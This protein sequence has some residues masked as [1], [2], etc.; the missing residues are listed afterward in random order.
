MGQPVRSYVVSVEEVHSGDDLVVMANLG[1]DG[2]HKRVRVRL[3]GVDTPN[4]YKAKIGTEAGILRDEI[5]RLTSG[6]CR[7][8]VIAEGKGGWLVTLHAF[9]SDDKHHE[10]VNINELLKSRGYVYKGRT[11]GPSH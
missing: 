6:K 2:L 3:H 8:D 7:V 11:D 5:K 4:A 10:E 1:I 9:V